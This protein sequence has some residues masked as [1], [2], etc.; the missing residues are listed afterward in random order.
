MVPKDEFIR[1]VRNMRKAQKQYFALTRA[2][3][4]RADAKELAKAL[5]DSKD[6][7][8]RTRHAIKWALRDDF[9]DLVEQMLEYQQQFFKTRS[10]EACRFAKDLERDVDKRLKDFAGDGREQETLF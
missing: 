8:R 6:H 5:D 9:V 4:P 3:H 10:S 2:R 1:I 7:E